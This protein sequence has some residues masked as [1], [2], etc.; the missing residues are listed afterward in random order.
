MPKTFKRGDV[1]TVIS[2]VARDRDGPVP[3][4]DAQECLLVL[5]DGS[6]L[7]IEGVAEVV[8]PEARRRDPDC[9]A[10]TY[11]M[12]VEDVAQAGEFEAELQVT[13]MTGDIR[14]FPNSKP[15][16]ESVTID[17]DLNPEA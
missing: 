13:W 1:G 7:V 14:T 16:N 9:G 5:G 6:G 17:P 15:S 8:A 11:T 12:T 3:L 10:W 2:G 4:G